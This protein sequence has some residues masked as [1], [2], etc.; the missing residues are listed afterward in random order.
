[1]LQD[2]NQNPMPA[3]LGETIL[4]IVTQGGPT[5]PGY[6]EFTPLFQ[7]NGLQ[8][9][10]NGV[11][12]NNDTKGIEGTASVLYDRYSISASGFSYDTDGWRENAD[13]SHD[14][15]NVFFQTAI[16]P[17][18]NAQLEFRTR[19]THYGDIEQ[20]WDQDDFA[21]G[22]DRDIDQDSYRGRLALV[23][24][25][26]LGRSPVDDLQRHQRQGKHQHPARRG[27]VRRPGRVRRRRLPAR[28]A[29]HLSRR[30]SSTSPRV[31][32]TSSS[33]ATRR[34]S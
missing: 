4:N 1:M 8:V 12:G 22:N 33:I 34:S 9:G 17:E 25:A 19:R 10:V 28:G 15:G 29:V 3:A 18:L 32:P 27:A 30:S 20:V 5:T 13:I 21:E 23:A 26:E 31:P 16:T 11:I 24:D 2:L 7:S 14:I 6:N